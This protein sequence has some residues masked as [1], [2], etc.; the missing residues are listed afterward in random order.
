MS[1]ICVAET[2]S[3]NLQ[4]VVRMKIFKY[5]TT[6][7]EFHESIVGYVNVEKNCGGLCSIADK[8]SPFSQN[9]RDVFHS[10]R[11]DELRV[12]S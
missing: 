7:V 8:M 1:G 4:L 3:S 6:S 11:T 10:V 9:S 5:F 2:N 12:H